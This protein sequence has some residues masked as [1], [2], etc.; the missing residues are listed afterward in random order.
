MLTVVWRYRVAVQHRA[1]FEAAYGPEGPWA[2]L[3]SESPDFDG[4]ELLSSDDG[5][6]LTIDRWTSGDAYDNFVTLHRSDYA[7]I[8]EEC[9]ELIESEELVG[10]FES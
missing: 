4:T 8:D 9:G 10:R 7:R 3:F 5:V 6:Y 1:V 2:E